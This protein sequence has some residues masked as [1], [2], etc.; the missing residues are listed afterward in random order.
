M[1]HKHRSSSV[2]LTLLILCAVPYGVFISAMRAPLWLHLVVSAVGGLAIAVAM[3]PLARLILRRLD[4]RAMIRQSPRPT[5][6]P[7]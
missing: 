7:R 4:D 5:N 2:Y 3:A 6:G 1:I